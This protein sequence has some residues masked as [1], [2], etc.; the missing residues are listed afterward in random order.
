MHLSRWHHGA[1]GVVPTPN[2]E[3]GNTATRGRPQRYPALSQASVRQP[4]SPTH[5]SRPGTALRSGWAH[6][7]GARR[8]ALLRAGLTTRSR[9]GPTAGHQAPATGTVYIFCGRGLASHRWPRLTSNGRPRRILPASTATTS[10]SGK[11]RVSAVGFA[12][13]RI[14]CSS[15]SQQSACRRCSLLFCVQQETQVSWQSIAQSH[16]EFICPRWFA[17][18]GAHA[19]CLVP[20]KQSRGQPPSVA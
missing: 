5:A 2:L 8:A 1:A 16:T 15:G 10:I 12:A 9:R 11:P 19:V 13:A 6:S 4:N 17:T 3:R 20:C 18:R 7:V 14:T